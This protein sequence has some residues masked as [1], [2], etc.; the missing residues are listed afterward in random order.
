V[1]VTRRIGLMGGTFDPIH[2][3]HL[4]VAQ[5][6]AWAAHLDEVR[7]IPARQPP[8]KGGEPVTEAHHR[9]AM[10]KAAIAGN[11]LFSVSTIEIDRE[12]PSFTVDTLR[13]LQ[14]PGIQLLFIMGLDSLAELLTWHDPSGIVALAELVAVYRRVGQ[15]P[16]VVQ[17]QLEAVLPAARD[18][19]HIVLIPAL[20]V[21]STEVR[22]RVAAGQ[23]IRYL[24]PD[25]VVDYI[26][27]NGLYRA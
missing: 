15:D 9:L 11:P 6:A 22:A 3:A 7:F 4:V 24:V 8:H 26:Q 12:G 5:E 17:H 25:H 19:V 21:S 1:D 23:P 20:D 13:E 27:T 14:E 10:T 18:R 16:H 2:I